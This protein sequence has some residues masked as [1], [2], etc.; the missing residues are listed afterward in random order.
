MSLRT[1]MTEQNRHGQSYNPDLKTM[2]SISSMK[3]R[4]IATKLRSRSYSAEFLGAVLVKYLVDIYNVDLPIISKNQG[5]KHAKAAKAFAD[6]CEEIGVDHVPAAPYLVA[7]FSDESIKAGAN[8]ADVRA[9]A[10]GIKLSL[11][12]SGLLIHAQTRL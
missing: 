6:W 7:K 3:A 12:T 9:L 10:A 11:P 1:S 4:P 5:R 8:R 2:C